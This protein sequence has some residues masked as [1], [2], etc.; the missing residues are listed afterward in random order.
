MHSLTNTKLPIDVLFGKY[1]QH[2][3]SKDGKH[4]ERIPIYVVNLVSSC[5]PLLIKTARC[6]SLGA[7]PNISKETGEEYGWVLPIC[8]LE[9]GVGDKKEQEAFLKALEDVIGQAREK[10][11]DADMQDSFN[12]VIPEEEVFKVGGCLWRGENDEPILYAKISDKKGR[13]TGYNSKIF[14]VDDIIR[15]TKREPVKEEDATECGYVQ[16][17]ICIDSIIVFENKAHLKVHVY[18]ANIQDLVERQ[19]FL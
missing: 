17:V 4:Y 7:K 5:E 15:P 10:V 9:E 2:G 1:S 13:A 19:T 16:A 18:E 11:R 3:T 14:K 12:Y 6:F 8:L